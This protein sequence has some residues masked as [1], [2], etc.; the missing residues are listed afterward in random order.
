MED[1]DRILV[2]N[3]DMT[4]IRLMDVAEVSEKASYAKLERLN[5][6]ASVTVNASLVTGVG[7]GEAT[8]EI[9]KVVNDEVKAP[10]GSR[11][12][13]EGDAESFN[14][15]G[16]GFATA[17]LFGLILLYLVLASL[18]E[19][20]F[21]P[22]LLMS[23]LPL[24]AGG[25]F[26][27]L[28]IMGQGIDMYSLIGILLLMGVATKNSIL[29]VDTVTEHLREIK[30][31]SSESYFNVILD[32]TVR[33]FRPI[34]MTSMSLIAGMIPI[35]VGL[36]EASAQR[37]SMGTAV[38]GGTISSTVLTLIV[39]P[40]LLLFVKKGMLKATISIGNR[41]RMVNKNI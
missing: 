31:P 12:V 21:L 27:A 34:I 5:R 22:V 11:I 16:V 8:N 14:E 1:L 38:I 7:L 28:L 26:V 4:P 20:F 18:Y 17:L 3:L 23:A 25:A 15:M 33:R 29:I 39:L 40:I 37:T 10:I 35:A 41:N 9:M 19:S 24:A 6:M 13:F 30:N 2:P 36:N 32:S